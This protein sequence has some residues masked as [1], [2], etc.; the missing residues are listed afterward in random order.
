LYAGVILT[1]DGPKLLEYNCRFGDPETQVILP[2]LK[3]DIVDIFESVIDGNLGFQKIEWNEKVCVGVVLA[4]GGY[5]KE[6]KK[7]L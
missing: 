6:Y 4:S 5:P 3:T 7:E 1:D 2:R